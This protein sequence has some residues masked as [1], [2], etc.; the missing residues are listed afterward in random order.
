M[1]WLASDAATVRKLVVKDWQ[2]YQKQLA[3]FVG[4]LLLALGMVGM[5]SPMWSAAG[6]LL[7][8]VLLV[9][10]GSYSVQSCV[11][12]ERKRQTQ[13]FVMSL[14]VSPMDVD[15]GKL[16][17]NLVIYLVPFALVVGGL[18]AVTLLTPAPDGA[19]PWIAIIA[20][21]LL[22]N[23]CISLCVAIA[24]DSEGWNTFTMLALMT[25][26]GPFIYWVNQIGGIV[27]YAKTDQIVWSPAAIGM[28]AAELGVIALAILAT[29]WIHARKSSFL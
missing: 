23:F 7:L 27:R 29:S 16:L 12:E 19:M 4:G 26:I 17:A 1:N 20:L 11:M 10:V 9:V 24:V 15:W 18:V 5:G 3:G 28:L 6:G 8:L 22:A 25:L 14:P 2:I 13:P 21:F